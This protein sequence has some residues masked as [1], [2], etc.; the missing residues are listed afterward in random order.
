M[1]TPNNN[2]SI[3]L[4]DKELQLLINQ[5]LSARTAPT[6]H[7][8]EMA[9]ANK[10]KTK[11]CHTIGCTRPRHPNNNGSL[12]RRCERCLDE[13]HPI[14][15]PV[16]IQPATLQAYAECAVPKC[17]NIISRDCRF[18]FC[19]SCVRAYRC[20]AKELEGSFNQYGNEQMSIVETHKFIGSY[21]DKERL[22]TPNSVQMKGVNPWYANMPQDFNAGD[23]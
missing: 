1:Q 17:K 3:D 23:S 16:F 7:D 14:K 8:I 15:V 19:E 22:N 20:I 4:T 21:W 2:N 10:D 11:V 18:K 9:Q 13:E 6:T 5:L 12:Y